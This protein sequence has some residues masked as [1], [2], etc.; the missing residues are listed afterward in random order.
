MVVN[1]SLIKYLLR[2]RH[3]LCFEFNQHE[4]LHLLV[5]YD[6]IATLLEPSHF[7][8]HLYANQSVGVA[9]VNLQRM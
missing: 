7:D 2:K 8:G 5:I 6:G 4:R 9:I 3:A 1:R